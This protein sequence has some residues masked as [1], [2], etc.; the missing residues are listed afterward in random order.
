MN[1]QIPGQRRPGGGWTAE[2]APGR[3]EK[4]EG[5]GVDELL[6]TSSSPRGPPKRVP[7][8]L[9]RKFRPKGRKFRPPE[10]PAPKGGN[11][12]LPPE[13][14]QKKTATHKLDMSDGKQWFRDKVGLRTRYQTVIIW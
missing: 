10:V 3:R 13:K 7:G 11:S 1:R 8:H 12:G 5:V 2:G 4:E 6:G 9:D 14:L